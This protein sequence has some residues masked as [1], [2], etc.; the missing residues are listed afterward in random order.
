MLCAWQNLH[1]QKYSPVVIL[2]DTNDEKWSKGLLEW[3]Y[4]H[5][6]HY[7]ACIVWT[8]ECE[9]VSGSCFIVVY[10]YLDF[11]GD[12]Q[13]EHIH[14]FSVASQWLLHKCCYQLELVIRAK[15]KKYEQT[16][17]CITMHYW[18]NMS[19]ESKVGEDCSSLPAS[20]SHPVPA[21]GD[22]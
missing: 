18:G 2:A 8:V 7:T 13:V 11:S 16:L 1:W 14:I 10:M 17:L 20:S 3:Y 19:L 9:Y 6:G 15:V 22:F 21:I 12:A 5:L 4:S